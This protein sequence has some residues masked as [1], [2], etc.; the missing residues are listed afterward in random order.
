MTHEQMKNHN[1]V[2]I[3]LGDCPGWAMYMYA[4]FFHNVLRRGICEAKFVRMSLDPAE[5][6]LNTFFENV[7]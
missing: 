2:R 6:Y 1:L 3:Y 7:A 4:T 5:C